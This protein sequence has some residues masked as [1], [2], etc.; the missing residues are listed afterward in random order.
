MRWVPVSNEMLDSIRRPHSGGRV[1]TR[2]T[3]LPDLAVNG[4][5]AN[6][7]EV[8]LGNQCTA[9][10]PNGRSCGRPCPRWPPADPASMSLLDEL[11]LHAQD[12]VHRSRPR[13]IRNQ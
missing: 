12:V 7:F 13:V 10:E 5:A 1:G 9:V 8:A 4:R 2:V 3:D 6:L 11:D